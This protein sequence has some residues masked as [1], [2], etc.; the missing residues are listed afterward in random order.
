MSDA[1][2]T[3]PLAEIDFSVPG[4]V[5]GVCAEKVRNALMALP[6]VRWAKPSAWHKRVMVRYDPAVLREDDLAAALAAAGFDTAS[7]H[8]VTNG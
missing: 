4:M 6:G 7:G 5:C 2:T 8:K 1:R 3:E